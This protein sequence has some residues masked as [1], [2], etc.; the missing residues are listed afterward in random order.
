MI[1]IQ[2]DFDPAKLK[3]EMGL[4]AKALGVNLA[5]ICYDQMRLYCAD[6][7]R[8]SQ[9]RK[10]RADMFSDKNIKLADKS[11]KKLGERRVV[12][13]INKI[14]VGV[15]ESAYSF[16]EVRPSSGGI[17]YRV[18]NRSTGKV[19]HIE[20]PMYSPTGLGV[21]PE[22]HQDRRRPEDGRVKGIPREKIGGHTIVNKAHVSK[23]AKRAYVAKT[24]ERVG[25]LKA[26]FTRGYLV[27]C[28][29]SGAQ[30]RIPKWVRKNMLASTGDGWG[31]IN[32]NDGRG[33]LQAI[34]RVRYA[35]TK[36]L[37]T[38]RVAAARTRQRDLDKHV[39]KRAHQIIER[40][41]KQRLK[42]AKVI[43]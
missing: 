30:P 33:A 27:F 28:K 37:M 4:V 38:D 31:R 42:S 26:G 1:A 39:K 24:I 34:N 36:L 13:D 35:A 8:R 2:P 21:L 19:Y 43:K 23:S 16:D 3:R 10:Q 17:L 22:L 9:P 41:N 14:A 6:M 15:N 12:L 7:V 25:R 29:R 40:A 20:P 32:P 11:G 5:F 18:E